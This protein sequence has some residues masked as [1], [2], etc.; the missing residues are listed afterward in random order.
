MKYEVTLMLEL[1]IEAPTREAAE[2]MLDGIKDSV[3]SRPGVAGVSDDAEWGED[4]E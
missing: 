1:E 2:R 3:W 4:C